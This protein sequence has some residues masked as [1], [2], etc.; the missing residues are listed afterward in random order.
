MLTA[1]D[2]RELRDRIAREAAKQKVPNPLVTQAE[3]EIES[4]DLASLIVK[5]MQEE[6]DQWA[7]KSRFLTLPGPKIDDHE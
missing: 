7:R 4:L 6:P 3:Q 5:S 2:R 1:R